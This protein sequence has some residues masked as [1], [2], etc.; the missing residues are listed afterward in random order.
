MTTDDASW[1]EP[2]ADELVALDL[3]DL[4][5]LLDDG[6][7]TALD[8]ELDGDEI[9]ALLLDANADDRGGAG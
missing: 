9:D 8:P 2:D 3:D 5:D 4:D 1:R 7:L 6:E